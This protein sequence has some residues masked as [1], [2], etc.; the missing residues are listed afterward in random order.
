MQ[1]RTVR[2]MAQRAGVGLRGTKLR[3]VRN[4][5][6]IGTGLAGWT[7]PR[8]KLVQLYPDAFLNEKALV[9]TLGHERTHVYQA[10]TFGTPHDMAAWARYERAAEATEYQWWEY[11]NGR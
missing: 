10:R 2:A 11:F 5:E 4:P 3:I 9:E 1:M 7:H 8:G 6:L